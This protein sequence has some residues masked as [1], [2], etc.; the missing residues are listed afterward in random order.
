MLTYSAFSERKNEQFLEIAIITEKS[1]HF[2]QAVGISML[3][4]DLHNYSNKYEDMNKM[5]LKS[6]MIVHFK[7]TVALKNK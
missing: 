2:S 5:N 7:M 1:L 6:E 3:P 4:C